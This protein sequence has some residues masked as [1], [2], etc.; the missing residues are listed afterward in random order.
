ME[1]L[2][3]EMPMV[4]LKNQTAVILSDPQALK[5]AKQSKPTKD[6]ANLLKVA[7]NQANLL[8][9]ALTDQLKLVPNRV[10]LLK[11]APAL[12]DQLKLVPNRVDLL[13][14][15]EAEEVV[16]DPLHSSL[17]AQSQPP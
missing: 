15:V 13:K 7:P 3:L 4:A 16:A 1:L 9:P 5:A 14:Q 6:K 11:P 2:N 17:P 8:K 10:N 12:A